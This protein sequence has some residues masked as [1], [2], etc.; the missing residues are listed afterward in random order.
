MAEHQLPKL[1]VRVRFSSPAPVHRLVFHS[2][3]VEFVPPVRENASFLG[4]GLGG[5]R[6]ERAASGPGRDGLLALAGPEQVSGAALDGKRFHVEP[7]VKPF[8][9]I[10]ESNAAPDHDRYQHDVQVVH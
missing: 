3:N 9:A 8:K 5:R 6:G 7:V 2:M 4:S 10:P 1:I